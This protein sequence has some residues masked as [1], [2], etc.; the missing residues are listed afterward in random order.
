M[1]CPFR[2]ITI[3]EQL[4]SK[5]GN[6]TKVDFMDCLGDECPYWGMPVQMHMQ[7]GG[8]RTIVEPKCR[9]CKD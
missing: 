2:T 1:K 8:W 5:E 6:I 3:T 7:T 4:Y 9:R